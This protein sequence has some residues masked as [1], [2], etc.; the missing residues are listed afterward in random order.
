MMT[1]IMMMIPKKKEQLTLNESEPTMHP[2]LCWVHYKHPTPTCVLGT[3]LILI[4]QI[5]KLRLPQH[6]VSLCLLLSVP[7][8]SGSAQHASSARARQTWWLCTS[9]A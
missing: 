6:I 2:V 4:L 1:M 3:V 9:L 8:S 5:M 7:W